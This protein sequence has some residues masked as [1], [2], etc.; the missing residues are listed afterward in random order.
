MVDCSGSGSRRDG[1][2]FQKNNTRGWQTDLQNLS[3]IVYT[4]RLH[5]KDFKHFVFFIELDGGERVQRVFN[6]ERSTSFSDAQ[7]T[8]GHTPSRQNCFLPH[9]DRTALE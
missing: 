7:Q 1:H 2:S 8:N 9:Q 4:E 3:R 5:L 6:Q